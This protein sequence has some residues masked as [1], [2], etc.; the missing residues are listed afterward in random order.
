M[1]SESMRF[2]A[3]PR[4]TRPTLI[5][6]GWEAR[7]SEGEAAAWLGPPERGERGMGRGWGQNGISSSSSRPAG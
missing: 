6:E 4:E 2:L 1:I 5:M 7:E 3:Q